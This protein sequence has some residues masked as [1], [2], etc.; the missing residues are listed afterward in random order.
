[1]VAFLQL[2]DGLAYAY[3]CI[4]VPAVNVS[5]CGARERRSVVCVAVA[6]DVKPKAGKGG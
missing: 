6:D 3:V 5:A 2:L 1:M 4:Q